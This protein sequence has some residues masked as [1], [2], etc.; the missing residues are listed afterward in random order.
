MQNFPINLIFVEKIYFGSLEIRSLI[1]WKNEK[2]SNY[3]NLRSK[4]FLWNI[5]ILYINSS[6]IMK[7]ALNLNFNTIQ[8]YNF[9]IKI[10]FVGKIFFGTFRSLIRWKN[11]KF[12][13][14]HNLRSK[15]FLWNAGILILYVN[16]SGI[17]K[18]ALNLNF[19][20]IQIYNF[21]IK[22]IFV[23]KIFFETLE[24]RFFM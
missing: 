8:I 7:T 24:F 12:S 13:N 17:V 15:N 22:I 1:R 9:L 16:P 4:N 10:I 19:N 5:S 23:G 11:E 18:T 21:L 6:G 14:Y 2:F 3:H 20:T